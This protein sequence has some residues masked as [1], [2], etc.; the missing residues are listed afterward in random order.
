MNPARIGIVTDWARSARGNEWAKL[1][2]TI[3]QR[4]PNE[5]TAYPLADLIVRPLDE[6]DP[7]GL[8]TIRNREILIINWDAANGDPDF[9]A[10][11]ALRWIDHRRPELLLWVR[12]GN[13]LIIESQATLGI[14]SSE[15]YGAAVGRGELPVSGP[16]DP[17]NPLSFKKRIGAKCAKTR[18]CPDS[19]GFEDVSTTI[20]AHANIDASR[21]F[22]GTATNLLAGQ[23]SDLKWGRILY[24]GWFRRVLPGRRKLRWVSIIRTADRGALREQSTMQVAKVGRGAIFASTM[25]LSTTDQTDLV[26]AMFKCMRG[27]TGHLPKPVS[28]VDWIRQSWKLLLTA[29]GGFIG[30]LFAF[31]TEV[32]EFVGK[33][34]FSISSETPKTLIKI[35]FVPAGML[36]FEILRRA[37]T[38]MKRRIADFIGY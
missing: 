31:S 27:Q 13:L 5:M 6:K 35:A 4:F 1:L 25:M 32:S 15:A 2:K 29:L 24:R 18:A 10:N 21:L 7:S 34:G 33:L 38:Y 23:I 26:I 17:E 16:E 12:E 30:G 11:L 20:E 36:L 37:I 14:P 19:D 3:Q 8:H 22:P 9:G 28:I